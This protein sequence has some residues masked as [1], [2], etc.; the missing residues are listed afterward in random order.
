MSATTPTPDPK[1]RLRWLAVAVFAGGLAASGWQII[2]DGTPNLRHPAVLSTA[3]VSFALWAGA[4]GVMIPAQREEWRAS[5]TRFRVARSTWILGAVMF[6]VH[7]LVAF[8]LAH[9]WQHSNA[10]EHVSATAGFGP[11]I[12]VS[13]F[14][15]ALWLADAAWWWL[16]PV[17]YAARSRWLG[18]L[19][20]TF[21]AFITFN[22]TV[23]YV[24]GWIRWM[25]ASV[26]V[27]LLVV[28]VLNRRKLL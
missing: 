28:V 2:R 26:F 24:T 21:I 19:T 22:G 10:F 11:G 14:F 5:G 8:H 18:W 23:V 25:A 13:Y 3:W 1:L 7:F 20:H 4:V 9:H 12:F 6:L 15:T 16:S 17:G 27:V